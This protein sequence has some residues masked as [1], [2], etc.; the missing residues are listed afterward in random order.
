MSTKTKNVDRIQVVLN[1]TENSL[2]DPFPNLRPDV[3][4]IVAIPPVKIGVLA[5]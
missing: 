3:I 4:P 1:G 2:F 5:E